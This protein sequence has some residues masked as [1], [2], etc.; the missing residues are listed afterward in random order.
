MADDLPGSGEDSELSLVLSRLRGS[1]PTISPRYFYDAAGS[2]LFDAITR[3]AEYYPTRTELSILRERGAG[4]GARVPA[5]AA[6]IELGSGSGDKILALL[7]H[8]DRPCLYRP[9]DISRAALDATC[10]ALHSA[11]PDLSLSPFLGD[12][13]DERAYRELPSGAPRL[14]YYSGSTIGNF[15]PAEA[16]AF[17]TSLRARLSPGDALLLAAD[18]VKDPAIL[19]AAYNDA[20][21]VTAAFNRNLLAHLNHRFGGTFDPADFEHRAFYEPRRRRIE[22]H[23]VP[24]RSHAVSLGGERL[25]LDPSRPIHTENSYKFTIDDLDGLARR[26]GFVVDHVETDPQAW[27]ALALFRA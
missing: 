24:L 1:P 23:L 25:E 12:F 27:F 3:T 18:L 6:L 26:A 22:M 7:E 16:V 20:A 21:G 10:A 5:G 2:R 8:L 14:V 17:L 9:I 15:E 4:L 11:R 13:T 19:H